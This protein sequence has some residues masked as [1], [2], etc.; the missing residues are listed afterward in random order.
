M[1]ETK[2]RGRVEFLGEDVPMLDVTIP[3]VL[4]ERLQ[5]GQSE[6][7]SVPQEDQ[8]VLGIMCNYIIQATYSGGGQGRAR[9]VRSQ[10]QT[11]AQSLISSSTPWSV[12]AWR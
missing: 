7:L 11:G 1:I 10:G 5:D 3:D 12:G 9:F 8:L 4:P 6:V 2:T